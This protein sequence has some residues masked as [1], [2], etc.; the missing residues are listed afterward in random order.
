[1]WATFPD[2]VPTRAELTGR[3]EPFANRQLAPPLSPPI[4]SANAAQC[5]ADMRG[6]HTV[7]GGVSRLDDGGFINEH[8]TPSTGTK[9]ILPVSLRTA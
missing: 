4:R 7:L 3:L 8:R 6:L 5:C 9:S 2:L 1:M